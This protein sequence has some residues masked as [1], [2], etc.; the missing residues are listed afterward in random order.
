MFTKL[1]KAE[2]RFREIEQ[3]ITLPDIVSN[4][5]TY[6]S[7]MREYKS[8]SPIIEK[9]REYKAVKRKWRTQTS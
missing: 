3:L 4:N 7:L 5:K 6:S 2:D 8:L 9:Y 1:E